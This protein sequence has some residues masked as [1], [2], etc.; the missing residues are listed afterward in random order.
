MNTHLKLTVV[1]AALLA[2]TGCRQSQATAAAPTGVRVTG[3]SD[4]EAGR[5]LTVVGGCNDCHT[6]GWNETGGNVPDA[7]RLTGTNVGWQGPW[8]VTYPAN[9]RLTAAAMSED[10]WVAMLRT[11]K[12]RPPMPWMNLN[13][14]HEQDSRAVYRYLRA[15]GPAGE[16]MPEATG[17]GEPARTA[18]IPIA[19]PQAPR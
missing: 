11:R 8:G 9:L 13:A 12:D 14:M 18:F 19:P 4:V 3:A 5:Y 16:R 2:L 10:D 17:P 6:A 1:A 7:Q 15:L